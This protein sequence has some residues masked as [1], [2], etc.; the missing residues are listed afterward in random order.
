MQRG[1]RLHR[2]FKLIALL[3]GPSAWTTRKLA[4]HFQMSRRNV[5]RDLEV[6]KLAGVPLYFDTE[7][8][9]H[10]GYRIRP[11]FLMPHIGLT[12]E[13]CLDLAVLTRAAESKSIP[14]LDEV[15]S[16]RDK[17]LSTLPAKQQDLILAASN[18]FEMLSLGLADHSHCRKIM[19]VL[20]QAL[21]A[22]KQ[23]T[24]IYRSPHQKKTVTVHLQPRRV[25]LGGGPAWYVAAQD[26]AEAVTKLY[27]IARFKT[28][29]MTTRSIDIDANWSLREFLGNAWGVHRG[30]RDWHVEVH[31][32]AEIA[33]QIREVQW[34]QTQELENRKDGS[35]IFRATVSGLEEITYWLLGFGAHAKAVKPI[36]LAE[37]VQKAAIATAKRYGNL[38][39]R[40]QS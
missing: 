36:E 39:P 6:L 14:L 11:G 22:Q 10:G 8:G 29:Q 19:L 24:G 16:V 13:E 3:R 1:Q 33:E 5:H 28:L 31:F 30:D 20:Q 26:N 27:R 35:L 34:H 9:E 25:F 23:V 4:E 38:N 12:D 37:R 17:I 32:D 2:V 15:S 18:L 40:E 21:L 7:Y